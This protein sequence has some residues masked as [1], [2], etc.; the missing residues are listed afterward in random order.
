[1]SNGYLGDIPYDPASAGGTGTTTGYY[2]HR[3]ANGAVF[4]GACEE[5]YDDNRI[6]LVR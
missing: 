2:F 1:V 4:I 6:E 5:D 3:D